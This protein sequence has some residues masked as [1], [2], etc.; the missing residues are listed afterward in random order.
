MLNEPQLQEWQR[1][2]ESARWAQEMGV[3]IRG[4]RFA[5]DVRK[6]L[7]DIVGHEGRALLSKDAKLHKGGGVIPP[8]FTDRMM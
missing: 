4:L 6:Q 3:D 8:A 1:A 2:G 5:R 7:T